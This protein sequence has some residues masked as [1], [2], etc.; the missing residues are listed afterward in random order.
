[1]WDTSGGVAFVG[2]A[3]ADATKCA[4]DVRTLVTSRCDRDEPAAF[5]QIEVGVLVA[6]PEKWSIDFGEN[7]GD[8]SLRVVVVAPAAYAPSPL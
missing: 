6:D 7:P 1:M 3:P 2:S 5:D 4:A 8:P